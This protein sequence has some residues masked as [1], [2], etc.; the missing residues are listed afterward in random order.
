M[1][2]MLLAVLIWLGSAIMGH[3]GDLKLAV[4]P[5]N[6]PAKLIVPMRIMAEFLAQHS[7]ERFTAIVTRDY[8]E[9]SQRLAEGTVDVAWIN[10]VN[11]IKVK[12]EQ[13]QLKYIATYMEREAQS[14]EIRPFYQSVII[15]L[16]RSGIK[17]LAEARG[18]RFAFTDIGSTSGY[19]YPSLMLKRRGIGPEIHFA[20]VF[21]L[22]KHDR[23]IEA[24]VRGAIDVGAV[25]DGTYYTAVEKHGAIFR[26]IERSDPI[27]LD[28]IV[29]P[30]HVPDEKVMR[31]RRILVSM[32]PDHP[33]C[34]AM[35]QHLGWNAAGFAVRDDA[36]YDGMREAVN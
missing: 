2:R 16:G 27:P 20:K 9:L 18:R 11:Y 8:A 25:S 4:Y 10:P 15:T 14:G 33:F 17:N 26:I 5:S 23:V 13:P 24:L 35:K 32:G 6:D 7:G 36:F 29:A 19:A 31:F 22:K 12:A 28:A 21:F 34:Q 30:V 1:I 3:A